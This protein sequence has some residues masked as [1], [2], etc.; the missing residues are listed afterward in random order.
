MFIREF[1][2]SDDWK[3]VPATDRTCNDLIPHKC[4]RPKSRS[5]EHH[6][7]KSALK[8]PIVEM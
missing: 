8:D 4:W 5:W 3:Y 2:N 1:N 7:K 6:L